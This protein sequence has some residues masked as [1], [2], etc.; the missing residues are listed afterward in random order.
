M[1]EPHKEFITTTAGSELSM[2]F[3]IA[4]HTKISKSVQL[5]IPLHNKYD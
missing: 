2:G 5:C 4:L 3:L 1:A